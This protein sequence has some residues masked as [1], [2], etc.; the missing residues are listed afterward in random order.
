MQHKINYINFCKLEIL[1]EKKNR[2]D[3]LKFS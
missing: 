2:L 1:K 3:K